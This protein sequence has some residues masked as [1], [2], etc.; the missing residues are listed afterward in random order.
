[1]RFLLRMLTR[2]KIALVAFEK[3]TPLEIIGDLSKNLQR[4]KY[5]SK[6][7]EIFFVK[8]KGPIFFLSFLFYLSE[9]VRRVKYVPQEHYI[10]S[11]EPFVLSNAPEILSFFFILSY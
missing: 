6:E 9:N 7:P 11:K 5:V 2:V 10:L 8:K 3:G 1:M 4:S